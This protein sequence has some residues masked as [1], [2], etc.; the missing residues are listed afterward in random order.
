MDT[1]PLGDR[2]LAII[3]LLSHGKKYKVIERD[4]GLGRS[5]LDR[6][7]RRAMRTLGVNA[8]T[9]LVAIALRKGWIE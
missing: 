7:I 5:T 1:C 3:K 9:A 6:T 2:E 4:L 8:S